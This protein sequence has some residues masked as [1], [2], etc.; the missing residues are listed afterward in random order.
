MIE[1]YKNKKNIENKS[2]AQYNKNDSL[3]IIDTEEK[4]ESLCLGDILTFEKKLNGNKTY[5]VL[6][7]LDEF[8]KVKNCPMLDFMNFNLGLT[9]NRLDKFSDFFNTG[10]LDGIIN[11]NNKSRLMNSLVLKHKFKKFIE[12]TQTEYEIYRKDFI[13]QILE[14]RDLEQLIFKHGLNISKLQLQSNFSRINIQ[15]FF[16]NN[17]KNNLLESCTCFIEPNSEFNIEVNIFNGV[18]FLLIL[19]LA[20]LNINFIELKKR[21]Y[22]LSNNYGGLLYIFNLKKNNEFEFISLNIN[23]ITPTLCYDIYSYGKQFKSINLNTKY[24][25]LR[26]KHYD[27]IFPKNEEIK[28]DSRFSL[29]NR[30]LDIEDIIENYRG[31][32]NEKRS[33]NIVFGLFSDKTFNNS[34]HIK[35]DGEYSLSYIKDYGIFCAMVEDEKCLI[36]NNSTLLKDIVTICCKN[37]F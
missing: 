21:S 14:N 32:S 23:K 36:N 25:E 13:N 37:F 11:I 27:L 20:K 19:D 28:I 18:W 35:A 3:L 10:K 29:E 26:G 16:F 8:L 34:V 30:L 24:V 17:R 5:L 22:T 12:N 33:L 2:C 7:T 1:K 9:L 15:R 4:F 6:V 31:I